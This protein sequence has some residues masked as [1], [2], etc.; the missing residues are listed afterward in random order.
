[1]DPIAGP[2]EKARFVCLIEA[3]VLV[4]L[5]ERATA[6]LE[7]TSLFKLQPDLFP[8]L[9]L[10]A[11]GNDFELGD[12]E[13]IEQETLAEQGATAVRGNGILETSDSSPTVI[14]QPSVNAKDDDDDDDDSKFVILI[15]DY[16]SRDYADGVAERRNKRRRLATDVVT[17]H[18][19]ECIGRKRAERRERRHQEHEKQIARLKSDFRGSV[20]IT[21]KVSER[22]VKLLEEVVTNDLILITGDSAVVKALKDQ[23]V[24]LERLGLVIVHPSRSLAG[25]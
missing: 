14:E 11:A 6:G 19:A 1:M 17:P 24:D 10:T 5:R 7:S 15:E 4:P 18:Q 23:R 8:C 2:R 13:L 12:I 25:V 9:I 21:K 20:A 16:T 3:R 22:H